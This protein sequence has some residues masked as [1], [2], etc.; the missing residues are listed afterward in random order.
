[1]APWIPPSQMVAVGIQKDQVP[2]SS[3]PYGQRLLRSLP[4]PFLK[5]A[6]AGFFTVTSNSLASAMPKNSMR[7]KKR[8]SL[9]DLDNAATGGSQRR[10]KRNS[11]PTADS[12][13]RKSLSNNVLE[14]DAPTDS[15]D[16]LSPT[17]HSK[18]RESEYQLRLTH[19]IWE[20]ATTNAN[21]A[22]DLLVCLERKQDIGFRYADVNREVVI[23]HGAKDTRVPVENV[24]W[25]ANRMRRCELRVL[26]DEGHGL[27]ASARVM[28]DVLGE[29]A[30]EWA[31]WNAITKRSSMLAM[32]RG[33]RINWPL[34]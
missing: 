9:N 16:S 25:L 17:A 5:V 12:R 31:D 8:R 10:T 34:R 14:S 20:A 33:E 28:G 19:A 13:P 7:R 15:I 18:E 22:V 3:L 23:H 32:Q 11:A 4:I 29:V 30:Q 6:N 26:E 21:P 24:E 27:M 2:N 1:M